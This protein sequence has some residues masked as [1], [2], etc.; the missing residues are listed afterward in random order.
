M[1]NLLKAE[2]YRIKKS[3]L[4]VAILIIAVVLPILQSLL[5]LG[6]NAITSSGDDSLLDFIPGKMLI[7][8][9]FSTNNNFGLVLIVFS[10]ILVCS[11]ISNGTLRNKIIGGYTRAQVYFA[12][13]IT[14]ILYNI[15]MLSIYVLLTTGLTLLFMDY[16]YEVDSE[17][18]KQIIYFVLLGIFAFTLMGSFTTFIALQVK[19]QPITIII[20][21]AST[22]LLS[23]VFTVVQTF[24]ISRAS[25]LVKHI[26]YFLPTFISTV[27]S[28][29]ISLLGSEVTDVM[30]WEGIGSSVFFGALFTLIGYLS[31]N[32]TDLK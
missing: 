16:G 10:G 29:G 7:S 15:V 6:L 11:D 21:I 19:S 13:L 31:F 24:F 12:H 18:M 25:E 4:T 5:Y 28:N 26:I 27:S 9:A 3:K 23:L 17:E 30:F 2:F 14:S 22:I 20:T 32:E 8:S 1:I